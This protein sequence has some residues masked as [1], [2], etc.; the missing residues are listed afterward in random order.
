MGEEQKLQKKMIA[1]LKEEGYSVFKTI[2]CNR[3]GI[4]DIIACS[5]TGRFTAIEV[6]APGKLRT[7]SPL[8]KIYIDEVNSRGGLAFVCDDLDDLKRYLDII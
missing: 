2:Q 7:L 5:P 1:V 8:Q 4:S 6:K 3:R